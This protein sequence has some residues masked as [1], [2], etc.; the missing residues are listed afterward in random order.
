MVATKDTLAR[1]VAD[2]G[3]I[4]AELDKNREHIRRA[5]EELNK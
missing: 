3:R 5:K 4:I 2:R 1:L